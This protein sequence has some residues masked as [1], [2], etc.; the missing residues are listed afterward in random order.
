MRIEEKGWGWQ[1][2]RIDNVVL[3]R[4]EGDWRKIIVRFA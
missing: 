3:Q 4:R 1:A 2:I